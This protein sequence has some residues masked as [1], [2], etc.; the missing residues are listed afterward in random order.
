MSHSSAIRCPEC[1]TVFRLKTELPEGKALRCKE[2]GTTFRIG[3]ES[4]TIEPSSASPSLPPVKQ[5]TPVGTGNSS[6]NTS[7]ES[8]T[9]VVGA[10]LIAAVLFGGVGFLFSVGYYLM[11]DPTPTTAVS[12]SVKSG[13]RTSKPAIPQTIQDPAARVEPEPSETVTTETIETQRTLPVKLR[14]FVADDSHG[15]EPVSMPDGQFTDRSVGAGRTLKR[16]L[17]LKNNY[18]YLDVSDKLLFDVPE[19]E[20]QPYVVSL[21]FYDEKPGMIDLQYDAHPLESNAPHDGRWMTTEKTALQGDKQWKQITFPLTNVKFANRQQGKADMRLRT[22]PAAA[23]AV[24]ELKLIPQ[25]E[26]SS[27][28]AANKASPE[29]NDSPDGNDKPLAP[30]TPDDL[31]PGFRVTWFADTDFKKQIRQEV[32]QKPIDFFWEKSPGEGIAE[33][34]W[35]ARYEGI[36]TIPANG[37]YEFHLT[38]DDG[39]RLWIDEELVIDNWGLH[40]PESRSGPAKLD[41]GLHTIRIDHFDDQLGAHLTLKMSHPETGIPGIVPLTLMRHDSRKAEGWK[42]VR[43][44]SGSK[45]QSTENTDEPKVL[46]GEGAEI[47]LVKKVELQTPRNHGGLH[48][49]AF[50][51]DGKILA[52][53]TGIGGITSGGKTTKFGGDVLLWNPR[54]G[55]I[56][57]TLGNHG[58]S[59]SSVMFSD[60][61]K[62]LVSNSNNNGLIKVWDVASKKELHSFQLIGDYTSDKPVVPPLVAI[63]PKG[64][65]L[66]A[67]ASVPVEEGSNVYEHRHLQAWN[68]RTGQEHWSLEDQVIEAMTFSPDGSMLVTEVKHLE[69]A[70]TD[71]RG[72]QRYRQNLEVLEI[73]VESGEITSRHAPAQKRSFNEMA[74]VGE[75]HKLAGMSS[76]GLTLQNLESS[77]TTEQFEWHDDRSFFQVFAF[78]SDGRY[79]LRGNDKFLELSD[80]KEGKVIGL[81]TKEFPDLLWNL[82]ISNDLTHIVCNFDHTPTVFEVTGVEYR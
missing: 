70:G 23:I 57:E 16:A 78:S 19:E 66:V 43:A 79:L 52:G 41:P 9:W 80:L 56:T 31:A 59:V 2:C 54:T 10:I 12:P 15:L 24:R 81:V 53:G 42:V 4:N 73:D 29:T 51:P 62:R 58:A 37:E 8:G 49:F 36:L 65:S 40:G 69:K 17:K 63:S 75:S 72:R 68:L 38:S 27:E 48:S 3:V 1:K 30:V 35:S 20:S 71:S 47:K 55:R 45:R 74:F 44:N 50:S 60:D 22:E 11:H 26:F 67:A 21:E 7:P 18:L 6:E 64:N 13:S 33:D 28:L 61:G 25:A 46:N 82:A 32:L 34:G 5:R 14:Y 76:G 77:E 39:S